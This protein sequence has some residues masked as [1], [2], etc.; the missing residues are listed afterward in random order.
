MNHDQAADFLRVSRATLDRWLRQGLLAEAGPTLAGFDR[1]KLALWARRRGI[2]AKPVQQTAPR[3]PA[4]LLA[5][6]VERGA[7]GTFE[8]GGLDARSAIEAA[9]AALNLPS[10]TK[11]V[12]LEATLDRERLASTGLG[13]GVAIPHPRHAHP[14]LLEE[15]WI[16][17]LFLERPTDWAALDGQP[18]HTVLLLLSP[19]TT[20]HLQ[21]LARIAFSLRTPGFDE[22]L[23]T[24]PT[25]AELVARLKDLTRQG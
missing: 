1:Q 24:R 11:R 12:L 2:V 21:L 4:H 15:A 13:H 8:K 18:V 10:E 17:V 19:N 22:F 14:E 3:T 20:V 9:M 7:V 6:A 23:R 16:S 25:Q 5:D